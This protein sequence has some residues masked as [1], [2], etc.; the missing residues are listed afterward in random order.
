MKKLI[1]LLLALVM[2]LSLCAC[3]GQDTPTTTGGD[4][5]AD[6]TTGAAVDEMPKVF[7]AGFGK[8]DITPEEFGVPMQGYG[9]GRTRL[10]NGLY[11]YI[12]S[13]ALAVRDAD[14]NTAIIISVDNAAVGETYCKQVAEKIEQESG[15]PASNVLLT[16][17][18]QHST[19]A[20]DVV[21]IPTSNRYSVLFVDRI[22]ESAL[23]ALDDLAP[24]EMYTATATADAISFVRHY[25]CKDGSYAGDNYGTIASGIVRHES[26]ADN[27]LQ[28]VKFVREGQKTVKGKDAENILFCNFQGHPHSGTSSGDTNISADVPGVFRDE[29]EAATDCRVMYVSGAQGNLN[30][31]SAVEEE[32]K[33]GTYKERGKSLANTAIKALKDD[34]FT[35]VETGKVGISNLVFEGKTDHT[36]DHLVQEATA[37]ADVWQRT[38][39]S[40]EAMK[41]GTSGE[42]HSVY[43]AEAIISKAK[44]GPTK[45]MPVLAISFGDV[46]ICGGPYEMFDTNGM[47][48]KAGSPFKMTFIANM[49]NG[50]QGY[51]P[52]AMSYKN[53][54]YSADI[55]RYAPGSG[56]ELRDTFLNMLKG[57]RDAQ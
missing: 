27:D 14:G 43:H 22:V 10:S 52:S 41:K 37:I 24:A 36:M 31:K 2:V 44:E 23:D 50:T 32:N 15:V 13:V 16:A 6:T 20:Y 51:I 21:D 47:E 26:E 9:N 29:V 39:N 3:G 55:T 46:A 56:E 28:M 1:S 53:G 4:S 57:L 48:I 49:V 35:K 17:I 30:M 12:Y 45:T 33:Y 18:H 38:L 8:A 54:C 5:V 11:S 19:P 40:G 7:M 25:L 42:I 34:A